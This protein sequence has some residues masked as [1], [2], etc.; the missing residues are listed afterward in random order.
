MLGN[1]HVRFGVGAGGET[2]P[3]YT[4]WEGNDPGPPG[5]RHVGRSTPE[6]ANG[7]HPAQVSALRIELNRQAPGGAGKEWIALLIHQWS[8]RAS[9]PI[10]TA[11]SS[12]GKIFESWG[13][14]WPRV[15]IAAPK[16]KRS[17]RRGFVWGVIAFKS[18]Q[19]PS[20]I[21]SFVTRAVR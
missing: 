18:C 7:Q 2:P 6:S 14:F 17:S 8:P 1:L 16:E 4:T 19:H 21:E 15:N 9:R 13:D 20:A 11:I 10:V 3:A 12:E 5:P